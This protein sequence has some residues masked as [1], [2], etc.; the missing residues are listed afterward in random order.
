MLSWLVKQ[1]LRFTVRRMLS[2][3]VDGLVRQFAPDAELIFPGTSSFAGR[4]AGREQIGAWLRRFAAMK[5]VYV[6][7]DVCIAGPPWNM[8]VAY[9]VSDRI[10]AHYSNEAV[11]WLRLRWFRPVQQRVFLDTE[12]VSV[13]EREHPEETARELLGQAA[14]S[15]DPVTAGR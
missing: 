8:R 10:G 4:F 2:G 12:R 5:P 9:H 3:H 11:V 14:Q 13:W 7:R 15:G 6:V 1:Y